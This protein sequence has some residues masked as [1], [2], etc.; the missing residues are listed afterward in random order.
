[1][2]GCGFACKPGEPVENALHNMKLAITRV[3]DLFPDRQ[4]FKCYLTG[5]GNFR[6]QVATIKEYKG[7][8]DKSHKP[9]HYDALR[10]YLIDVWKAEVVEGMEADD[11]IG[12]EQFKNTDKSTVI[13]SIDKDMNQIPGYHYN[14]RKQHFYYVT[15][16]AADTFFWK[17]MMVGDVTDNI[18]GITGIGD[19]KADKVIAECGGDLVKLEKR[20]RTMYEEQYRDSAAQAFT[21]VENL[22]K[23]LRTPR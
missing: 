12:I 21:E 23:I 16:H 1:M 4:Y 8:R 9:E 2:Y 17:Q 11:A 14:P 20:V 10:Q 3:L 13:V 5:S 19:K 15:K 7:N 6:E 18:P 22:I